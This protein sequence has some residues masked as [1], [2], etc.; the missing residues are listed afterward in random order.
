[1]QLKRLD[2]PYENYKGSATVNLALPGMKSHEAR[3]QGRPGDT[4][5]DRRLHCKFLVESEN[6]PQKPRQVELFQE[7]L[8]LGKVNVV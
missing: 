6:F 7:L 8:D 5:E 3:Y 1:M 4:C 2:K